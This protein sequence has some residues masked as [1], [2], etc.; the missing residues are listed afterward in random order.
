MHFK[1]GAQ[2]FQKSESK[3]KILGARRAKSRWGSTDFRRHSKI[4]IRQ[5]ELA[6]GICECMHFYFQNW[7]W[8][9]IRLV[10]RAVNRYSTVQYVPADWFWQN[11]CTWI[12]GDLLTYLLTPRSTIP[13]KK[14]T[15]SE[16]VKNFT[17]FY[18]SRKFIT[19]FTSARHLSLSW[20]TSIQ[21]MHSQP[22]S[23]RS[24]LILS[25]HLRLG[26]PSG[27]FP[28]SFSI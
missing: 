7:D 2:I 21:S 20:A 25:Y 11:H 23:W 8:P 14:L 5:G 15:G 12:I 16:L 10:N 22:I 9:S 26:L 19:A 13:L 24:I 3:L 1:I 27:L 4:F 17:A 18:V 6:S 28:S